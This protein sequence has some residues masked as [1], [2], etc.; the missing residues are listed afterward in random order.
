MIAGVK[1]DLKPKLVKKAFAFEKGQYLNEV[2]KMHDSG[3]L[4]QS[5]FE[6]QLQE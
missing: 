4:C 6:R 2:T 5:A 1:V 3:N